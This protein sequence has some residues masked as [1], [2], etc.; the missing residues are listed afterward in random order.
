MSATALLSP[1]SPTACYPSQVHHAALFSEVCE[2]R[3]PAPLRAAPESRTA[4][5]QYA[6]LFVSHT[7]MSTQMHCLETLAAMMDVAY[8]RKI[9]NDSEAQDIIDELEDEVDDILDEDDDTDD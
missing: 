6:G 9:K 2:Q 4:A 8:G 3:S 5:E 7:D 1:A